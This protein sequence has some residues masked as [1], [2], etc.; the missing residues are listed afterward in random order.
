MPPHG[1][2]PNLLPHIFLVVGP[3]KTE[4]GQPARIDLPLRISKPL[5]H[6]IPD[7]LVYASQVNVSLSRA[8]GAIDPWVV[9]VCPNWEDGHDE[10]KFVGPNTSVAPLTPLILSPGLEA[11]IFPGT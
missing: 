5:G 3:K 10:A 2:P 4:A 8:D 1:S 9:V 7:G 6:L 11:L